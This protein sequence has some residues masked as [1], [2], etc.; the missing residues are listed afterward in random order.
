LCSPYLLIEFSIQE[1]AAAAE[2][3]TA[4]I[5]EITGMATDLNKMLKN[6][7]LK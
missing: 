4:S 7:K 3:V 6:Y 1:Q 2:E 5:E